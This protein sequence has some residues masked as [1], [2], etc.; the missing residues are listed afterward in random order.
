MCKALMRKTLLLILAFVLMAGAV[1]A[2]VVSLSGKIVNAETQEPVPFAHLQIKGS[3]VGT[4]S[5]LEGD[6]DLKLRARY[7]NDQQGLLI[8][9]IGYVSSEIRLS[10]G[11][12]PSLTVSLTP[13][14]KSLDEVV[15][16][17]TIEK[18]QYDD[19]ARRIA[20]KAIRRIPQNY[21][22]SES[23]GRAFYRHYCAE[24]D[25][26]VRLIEAALD[27]YRSGK[28][29]YRSVIPEDNLG[30]RVNQLRRSFDFTASSKLKHPPFSLNFL[31]S[32]DMTAYEYQ[33]PLLTH[34]NAV[35]FWIQ[36]TTSY[37]SEEVLVIGYF[38][39]QGGTLRNRSYTGQ[40]FINMRNFAILQHEATESYESN[41]PT[42]GTRYRLDK[43]V[44]YLSYRGKH[45][46][47]RV[48]SDLTAEYFQ[49]DSLGTTIDSLVH[50]SHIELINTELVFDDLEPA[51]GGEPQQQQLINIDYDST[52]WRDYTVLQAT[53]L[54]EKIINDLSE[55]LAIEQQ[56][57]LYNQLLEGGGSIIDSDAFQNMASKYKGQPTYFIL[58]SANRYP[59]L[60]DLIPKGYFK[61]QIKKG[62]AKLVLVGLGMDE[63]RWLNRRDAHL[64]NQK[65]ITHER[66]NYQLDKDIYEELY[67]DVLPYSLLT[68]P[69]GKIVTNSPAVP[70]DKLMKEVL[71]EMRK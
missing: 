5:N 59:S 13:S 34:F 62:K 2:Q 14:L 38:T 67:N 66:L 50:T 8:S 1:S 30:F 16:N 21:I 71:K 54:E 25:T 22:K 37:E 10:S 45:Y 69:A 39:D 56:F 60:L 3:A 20:Q 57:A 55:K 48:T 58:W 4:S 23:M 9:C 65:H 46:L 52:F 18:K 32:N 17:G 42:E 12:N 7:L 31:L 44:Q 19:R 47:N 40:L 35:D 6:F 63:L 24:N 41:Y 51:L 26:Y 27:V 61:R 53:S 49:Y 43:K 36:D 29:P 70:S 28:E 68:D 64:L 15:I 11:I 33:N